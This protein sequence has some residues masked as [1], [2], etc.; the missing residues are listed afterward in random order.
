[1][2]HVIKLAIRIHD[3]NQSIFFIDKSASEEVFSGGAIEVNGFG[4][5]VLDYSE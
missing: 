1:M 5:H 3:T 4:F 2:S